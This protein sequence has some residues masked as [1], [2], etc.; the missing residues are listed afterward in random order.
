MKYTTQE[1]IANAVKWIEV[2]PTA[3]QA[4]EIKYKSRLGDAENGYC[5][6]GLGCDVIG[7][8]Y[9]PSD[10][11]SSEFK[12]AVGLLHEE[13]QLYGGTFYNRTTLA[14]VNDGT[15]AGFKR[16]AKFIKTNPYKLFHTDVAEGITNHYKK[17]DTKRHYG[18]QAMGDR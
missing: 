13:G 9:R 15:K 8:S 4:T 12:T 3:K 18:I 10:G 17:D 2:L 1:K 6:L 16:I 7:L 11:F 14:A 5:C